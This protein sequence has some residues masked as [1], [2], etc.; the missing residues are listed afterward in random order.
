MTRALFVAFCCLVGSS[1]FAGQSAYV[2]PMGPGAESCGR[3]LTAHDATESNV[4]VIQRAM[5][6]S[7]VQGFVAGEDMALTLIADQPPQTTIAA[8]QARFGTQSGW[9]FDPPDAEAMKH[10]ITKFCREHPLDTVLTAST[11]LV[12]ALFVK[13]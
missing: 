6:L 11:A 2:V 4:T 9:V 12:T 3:W 7:W 10:W 13:P 1:A 5:L 8:L